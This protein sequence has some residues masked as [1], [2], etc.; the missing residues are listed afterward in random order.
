MLHQTLEAVRVRNKASKDKNFHQI[1][2]SSISTISRLTKGIFLKIKNK[3]NRNFHALFNFLSSIIINHV[4]KSVQSQGGVFYPIGYGADPTGAQDSSA[5]ILAALNDAVKLQN[6]LSLLPGISDLG[7]A[8][9]D[10]QGGSFLISSPIRFP[11]AIGNIVVR[12][13]FQEFTFLFIYCS[14]LQLI[15]GGLALYTF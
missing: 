1:Y 5:A 4:P 2:N 12:Y 10:L 6:G 9:I 13:N 11:P 3:K 8:V 14:K 15:L 7:G